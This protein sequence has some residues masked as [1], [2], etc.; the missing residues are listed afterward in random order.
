[1][2]KTISILLS[3]TICLI[4]NAQIRN[5]EEPP[6]PLTR[7][8]FI[9][10]ASTSMMERWEGDQKF[11][12]A[13]E[14][15]FELLDSLEII[16]EQE[17]L[18]LA[19][20]V[21]GH[22]SPVP[23]PDCLDSKLEVAFGKNTIGLMRDK[24]NSI[25]PKGTTPIA[26]SLGQ[27]EAD[28]PK[29]DECRNIII[30]ITDGIEMC[31]GDPCEVSLALQK[32]GVVLKPYIIGVDIKVELTD[33]LDCMGNYF[34]AGNAQEFKQAINTIV[35]QVT[36]LT[37]VTVNLLDTNGKPLE[38][39]AV[40]SFHD[41]LSGDIRYTYMHTM[42]EQGKPDTIY[43]DLLST[44][45]LKVHTIPARY[46]DS[47]RLKEGVHNVIN[48]PAP[49]GVLFVDMLGDTS[50]NSQIKCIIRNAGIPETLY[51]LDVDKRQK[52]ITGLYN[53]EVL[54]MPRLYF[55][56]VIIEQN[57]YN[58]I[59]I[60]EPGEVIINFKSPSYGTLLHEHGDILTN[61]Y[62]FSPGQ[63]HYKFRL[64]PGYYRIVYREKHKHKAI[65]TGE[66]KFRVKSSD[67]IIENL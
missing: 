55:D 30:L 67:F 2:K 62:D 42:N 16:Q 37:T 34:N 32:K 50:I 53:I 4:A 31:H 56:A 7:I 49:Q 52:L 41:N 59:V 15:M 11:N 46:K 5:F 39:N 9:F 20:R 17:N 60:Q 23:P 66:S 3:L 54:T 33:V 38:T 47:I 12:K 26:Y 44:Y 14:L 1:M 36:N 13:K 58:H 64:Q 27:S 57:G 6:K 28:F 21:Y 51:V 63:T 40:L 35:A 8:L 19:L 25:V 65:N 61:L 24:L 43:L 45:D 18:E 22:Q 10:D 48:V 29:C